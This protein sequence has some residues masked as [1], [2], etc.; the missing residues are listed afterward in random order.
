MSPKEPPADD[1][2]LLNDFS[3]DTLATMRAADT[4]AR[5]RLAAT[6]AAESAPERADRRSRDAASH[7]PTLPGAATF[8]LH[9]PA[10]V[11]PAPWQP[12]CRCGAQVPTRGTFCPECI[13][14]D[15][16]IIRRGDLA[17]AYESVSPDGAQDWCRI[18]CQCD[19]PR[20]PCPTCDAAYLMAVRPALATCDRFDEPDRSVALR[21]VRGGYRRTDGSLLILGETGIGKTACAVAS[22]LRV[23]DMGVA[24]KLDAEAIR[25]AR[26]I[27]LVTGLEVARARAETRLGGRAPAIS[28]AEG[29]SLLIFDEVGYE[30]Q[31]SDPYAIRDILWA[32]GRAGKLTIATS[33]QTRAAFTKRYGQPFVRR[34][35]EHGRVI[36]LHGSKR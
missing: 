22:A 7:E 10:G 35:E 21:I 13:A 34:L 15:K 6:L 16:R 18:A 26:G 36:D 28:D 24:G 8:D 2:T 3:A 17:R 23:L 25:F 32:R 9:L 4:E 12:R 33:G 14:D 29:A 19:P 11:E 30:A 20:R 27:R 31:G 5:S 1:L